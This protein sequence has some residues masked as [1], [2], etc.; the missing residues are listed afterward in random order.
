MPFK[1]TSAQKSKQIVNFYTILVIFLNFIYASAIC[2]HNRSCLS[3]FTHYYTRVEYNRNVGG[4]SVYN[5]LSN[6]AC[7][8]ACLIFVYS[9]I[10]N[11]KVRI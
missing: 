8:F 4:V 10:D 7:I 5:L 6:N 3:H 2:I 1:Y 9:Y 11:I